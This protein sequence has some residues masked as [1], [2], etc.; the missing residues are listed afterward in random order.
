[1]TARDV[2]SA[3]AV[4]GG[5]GLLGLIGL[6]AGSLMPN[7]D[8]ARLDGPASPTYYVDTQTSSPHQ[9][10]S[11]KRVTVVGDLQPVAGL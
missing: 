2:L 4:H 8:T 1:M 6:Y 5:I 3:W 9:D 7:D 10:P 11:G